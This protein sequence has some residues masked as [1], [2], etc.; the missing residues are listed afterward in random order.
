MARHEL[1]SGVCSK[2]L[3]LSYDN[4]TQNVTLGLGQTIEID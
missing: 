2:A 3:T 1:C 4:G